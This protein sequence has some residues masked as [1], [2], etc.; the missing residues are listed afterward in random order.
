M[1]TSDSNARDPALLSIGPRKAE[2]I[3]VVHGLAEAGYTFYA[4]QGTAEFIRLLGYPV[5]DVCKLN[6]GHPDIL[7]IISEGKVS[8][9]VNT[10]TGIV[11]QT[12][13]GWLLHPAR[14]RGTPHPLLYLD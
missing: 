1:Q 6:E 5:K 13:L 9:I 2:A 8:C 14:C 7:D 10:P 12:M 3:S 4:T 11:T